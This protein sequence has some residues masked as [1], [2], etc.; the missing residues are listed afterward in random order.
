LDRLEEGSEL[1]RQ[2]FETT[3]SLSVS[4]HPFHPL[5]SNLVVVSRVLETLGIESESQLVS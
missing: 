2:L 5:G 1:R 4:G 3:N